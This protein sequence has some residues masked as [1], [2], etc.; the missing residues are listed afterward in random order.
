MMA[1]GCHAVGGAPGLL[2]TTLGPGLANAV[3]GIADASQEHVPLIVL[4]GVVERALRGRYTHQILDHA[5]LLHPLVKASFEIEAEGAAAIV[6]RA[7][8]IAISGR[9]GP[10]HLDLSPAVA[11]LAAGSA[12]FP[13]LAPILRPAIASLDPII[14]AARARFQA[15]ERPLILAG[16]EALRSGAGPIVDHLAGGHGVP[17]LTTY[18]AKGLL[19]ERHDRALGGAGLSPRADA[20]LL[21]LVKRAD[22]VL[23]AGYDPIEMRANWVGPFAAPA[24]VIELGAWP[25]DHGMHAAG[26][27]IAGD[28]AALLG[29]IADGLVPRPRWP[30]GEIAAT[31]SAL[32]RLFAAPS[33]WGPHAVI[34]TLE[35][36]LPDGAIVTAD[37]G[38]HRILLSQKLRVR[39]PGGLLQSAGFCTMGAALPLAIGARLAEPSRPVVAVLGDGGLEMTLGELGTLRDQR[40]AVT[41]LVLQDQSLA[42]IELKQRQAGLEPTGVRLGATD[43][44]AIAVAFG[45]YG[46]TV[47]DAPSLAVALRCAVE[48][49]RFTLITAAIQSTDY[50][51]RL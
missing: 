2:V 32:A 11:A 12:E 47:R 28:P 34:E 29:A 19:D 50:V 26:T 25:A 9:P 21:P 8:E 46:V 40:L 17:V 7:V 44:G 43:Y 6:R 42:L 4:S 27:R 30:D 3:N 18:K 36:E 33:A 5:A 1:A 45:G 10:V 13:A 15:A 37:S 14:A 35:A 51:D 49:D 39:R 24:T 16:T 41:L 23:A 31:R 48:A 22:L 20:V 38:A